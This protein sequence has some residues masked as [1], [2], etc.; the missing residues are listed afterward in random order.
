CLHG[1]RDQAR[2]CYRTLTSS[3]DPYLRGEGDWGLERY[4]DANK[5]FRT[6]VAEND[7]NALYRIRWGMLLH[8]RFNNTDA[9]G[10]FKEALERDPK[11]A[12]AYL[13]LAL[14]SADGFDNQAIQYVL[15]ALELDPKLSEAH[16][17][18][19]NL[20]LQDSNSAQATSE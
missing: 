12:R 2:I 6:A 17:L 8:E 19:A 5:D 1:H 9:E 11:S 13:G 14:V 16:E 20:A 18:F 4:E 10:L 7:G 3:R 15:K